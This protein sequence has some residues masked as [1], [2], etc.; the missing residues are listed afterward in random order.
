VA[1]V[2]L[3]HVG[4]YVGV[5]VQSAA[6]CRIAKAVACL[7]LVLS[8]FGTFLADLLD[9]LD[10]VLASVV[11]VLYVADSVLVPLLESLQLVHS[12]VHN[13]L[14]SVGVSDHLAQ[15][16]RQL[17][18]VKASTEVRELGAASLEGVWLRIFLVANDLLLLELIHTA[19]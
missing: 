13:V 11:T 6:V 16:G 15:I 3:D 12:H 19:L 8:L 10:L 2:L 5:G 7:D 4:V 1:V 18:Q 17:R 9:A 14:A